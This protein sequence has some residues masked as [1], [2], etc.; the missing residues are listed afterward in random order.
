MQLLKEE[1]TSQT[2]SLL[3]SKDE[4][5]TALIKSKDVEAS[6]RLA[7]AEQTHKA[8]IAALQH[9]LQN[10]TEELE[11]LIADLKEAHAQVRL[12]DASACAPDETVS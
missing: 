9:T 6:G 12:I 3:R 8:E 7:G 10:K 1:M 5:H 2:T 11:K 4:E